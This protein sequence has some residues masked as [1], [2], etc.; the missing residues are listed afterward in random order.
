MK[1]ITLDLPVIL[2]ENHSGILTF[3]LILVIENSYKDSVVSSSFWSKSVSIQLCYIY[4]ITI[5]SITDTKDL[6]IVTDV[7]DLLT[8]NI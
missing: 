7:R 2:K 5:I 8:I 4:T 3:I 6:S 1:A